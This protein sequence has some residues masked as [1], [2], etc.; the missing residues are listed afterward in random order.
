MQRY[1]FMGRVLSPLYGPCSKDE[2]DRFGLAGERRW[3]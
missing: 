1:S 3:R 2:N